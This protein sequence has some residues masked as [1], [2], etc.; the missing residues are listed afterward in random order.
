VFRKFIVSSPKKNTAYD[1]Y[2]SLVDSADTGAFK[3]APTIAAGDFQV[4]GD[5]AAFANLAT[6]PVVD[7]AGSIG[8]KVSLSAAEMNFN[9]IMVQCIDAAGDEWDDVLI[10]IDATVANVD[11]VVRSTTPANT[12]DIE[13]GGTAGIDLGNVANQGAT[14]DLT[15]TTII[16]HK[17]WYVATTGND[18][19]SGRTESDPFLTPEHAIE[20]AGG[21]G[22]T[23]KIGA[24][25]FGRHAIDAGGVA[26]DKGGGLVGIPITG[27]RFSVGDAVI[28]QGTVNY[29]A[30]ETLH[31]TTSANELVITA[32]Y[33]EEVFGGA[34][35]NDG[36]SAVDKGGGLVGIP[37][38][39]HP[40]SA[41]DV[42][43]ISGTTNYDGAETIVSET[44]NEIVITATYEIEEF[45]GTDVVYITADAGE[46]VLT[47]IIVPK[48][49]QK[50]LGVG[51]RA[52]IINAGAEGFFGRVFDLTNRSGVGLKDLQAVNL[53]SAGG[54]MGIYGNGSFGTKIDR[55]IIG[56]NL[57][58]LRLDGSDLSVVRDSYMYA[59][60]DAAIASGENILFDNCLMISAGVGQAGS[61]PGAFRTALGSTTT[62]TTSVTLN[63]C[64]C[65]MSRTTAP[66]DDHFASAVE[67]DR[68]ARVTLI[69]T[70][71]LATST[72][73][74][75]NG[76]VYGI[77]AR[78]TSRV[79]MRGGSIFTDHGGNGEAK[80]TKK[81][82]SA[83]I[84]IDEAAVLWDNTK[85]DGVI[86]TPIPTLIETVDTVLD[87]LVVTVG[88]AG[89]G[90]TDLGGMS[91][92]MKTEIADTV[93]DEVNTAAEHNV[94]SS[95][96]RQVR[97]LSSFVIANDDAEVSNSPAINQIQLASGESDVD[98]TFDPGLVGIVAGA[99]AGQCR[100]ILEYTGATRIATLNRD[101]KGSGPDATS[102][103]IILCTDGGLH[104]NEG[105]CGGGGPTSVTL[106]SLA[107]STNNI[108]NGQFVFLVSGT[109]QDQ[110]GRVTAYNGTTKVAT[111]ET[112]MNGWA[113]EPVAGTGYI[114]MPFLDVVPTIIGTAG[115]GLTDLGGLSLAALAEFMTV[116]TLETTAVA[117]SVAK[118]AQGA[119]G[120]ITY[121]LPGV[122]SPSSSGRIDPA[123]LTGYQHTRLKFTRII[124]D[125]DGTAIDL[126][127]VIV[128]FKAWDKDDPSTV[129]IAMTSDGA[130]AELSIGGDD[131]NEVTADGAVTHTATARQM[132]WGL[133]DGDEPVALDWGVLKIEEGPDLA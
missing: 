41:G 12:L 59:E 132:D 1:F 2:I 112:T 133:Y 111:I 114:M 20:T 3:A 27:H 90:L 52:T 21:E 60:Y 61:E 92:G 40:F 97:Q 64:Y 120:G 115:V 110:V 18:S 36:E 6:L 24:G 128:L 117:G 96:G 104:V 43:T 48:H 30:T 39:A 58:G 124:L 65:L 83:Q 4:S 107:S 50:I 49:G 113:T 89:L 116:D 119:A 29:D 10:F 32:A 122:S 28:I 45:S 69:D 35:I 62:P 87:A 70:H 16:K 14:L 79:I 72:D 81:E 37:I 38:T 33:V 91:T 100:L 75:D 84:L 130:G 47:R 127:A 101:W 15:G 88:V 17:T 8:V 121:V 13:A 51:C 26:V 126:S 118:I 82:D 53:N 66:G 31:A 76:D 57:D 19:N 67:V 131:S 106:N 98:G 108:Y 129:L 55:C 105:L 23:I 102:E 99:A 86:T 42:V 77:R 44:A 125:S 80:D 71:I 68:D 73:G 78:H 34:A 25:T 9:K 95:F 5:G 46:A 123:S 93:L 54:G 7:P 22:D 74:S 94:P 63:N 11:D 56:G 103:Y 85:T 109:G